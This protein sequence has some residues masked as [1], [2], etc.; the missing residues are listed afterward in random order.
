MCAL[1]A[2]PGPR[3][4]RGCCTGLGTGWDRLG[5]ART[6]WDR[7]GPAGTGWD[8]LGPGGKRWFVTVV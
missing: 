5:P 7:L 4:R 6:G 2:W 8:R 1:G 3:D